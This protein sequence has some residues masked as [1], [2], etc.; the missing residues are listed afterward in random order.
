MN[1]QQFRVIAARVA[2]PKRIAACYDV[3][4]NGDSLRYAEKQHGLP[5]K[6]LA[7][8]VMKITTMFDFCELIKGL[9]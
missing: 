3:V 5:A 1:K 6:T 8:D 7:N 9:G 4:F 2:N